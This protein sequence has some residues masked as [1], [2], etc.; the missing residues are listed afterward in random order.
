MTLFFVGA[1]TLLLQILLFIFRGIPFMAT[2]FSGVAVTGTIL[3]SWADF[4]LFCAFLFS[5]GILMFELF[6]PQGFVRIVSIAVV[7]LSIVSLA[8]LNFTSAWVLVLVVSLL[9]FIYKMSV[10][11]SI[12][13]GLPEES[14]K[15]N[16]SFPF[17]SFGALVIGLFF[18]L[19]TATIGVSLARLANISFNDIRPSFAT[20]QHVARASLLHDPLFGV[21]S[22]RYGVAWNSYHPASINATAYW[23]TTFSNG[24]DMPLTMLATLGVVPTALFIAFFIYL[25]FIGA[26]VIGKNVEDRM[27]RFFAIT[28]LVLYTLLFVAMLLSVP[29]IVGVTLFFLLAGLIIGMAQTQG[30]LQL[31]T[32]H[33][34]TDPRLSFFAVTL[35][36]GVILLGCASIYFSGTKF[37]SVVF[38]NRA[39]AT[40]DI[41]TALRRLGHADALSHS[42]LYYRTASALYMNDFATR[43]RVQSPDMT[44]LQNDFSAAEKNATAAVSWDAT[45]PLNWYSLSQVYQ[46]AISA[47]KDASTNA[48]TALGHAQSLAPQ[49]PLFELTAAQIALAQKDQT[50]AIGH[51]QKAIALK[52][53][54]LDAYL[55]QA[56]LKQTD[57]DLQGAVDILKQYTQVAPYDDQGYGVLG[58]AYLSAKDYDAASSAFRTARSINPGEPNYY[59]LAIKTLYLKGDRTGAAQETQTFKKL[60]PNQASA[61]DNL[62]Q[63]STDLVQPESTDAAGTNP[64][65][66]TKEKTT[67][68]KKP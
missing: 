26:R 25:L 59:L 23:N 50:G 46:L 16:A 62:S 56:Q 45:N 52:S 57:G 27:S 54:Y 61:A 3:G 39:L 65:D 29:G 44:T 48:Q 34:L 55:L 32:L 41:Q 51:I 36:T 47:N 28:V 58:L 35:M 53:N 60:F 49:N 20:S 66:D 37:A 5:F 8:F 17:L 10:E 21:G 14:K 33:F 7:A 30:M 19:S 40:G 64:S 13:Y 15:A 31:R 11:R 4:A 24:Y 68:N 43:S 22:G 67:D 63:I 2:Y 42:D 12:R 38:Y 9:L 18:F 6:A 1:V